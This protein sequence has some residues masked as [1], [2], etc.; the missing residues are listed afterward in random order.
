M[1]IITVRVA[2][3]N[4]SFSLLKQVWFARGMKINVLNS[5]K[6]LLLRCLVRNHLLCD[7][8]LLVYLFRPVALLAERVEYNL[9]VNRCVFERRTSW[10]N[11]VTCGFSALGSLFWCHFVFKGKFFFFFLFPEMRPIW[12]NLSF[13]CFGLLALAKPFGFA[14]V[15][16][17]WLITGDFSFYFS[18]Y[19]WKKAQKFNVSLHALVNELV[20]FSLVSPRFHRLIWVYQTHLTTTPH[21]SLPGGMLALN[22]CTLPLKFTSLSC[23]LNDPRGVTPKSRLVYEQKQQNWTTYNKWKRVKRKRNCEREKWKEKADVNT[24]SC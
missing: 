19:Y 9:S 8:L 22:R 6:A 4:I 7:L 14:V 18:A 20:N 21:P 24:S 3:A 15:I 11:I 10:V 13:L 23:E 17:T 2:K 16:H 5:L 12:S 1:K